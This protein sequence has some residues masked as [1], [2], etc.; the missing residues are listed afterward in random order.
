MLDILTLVQ[1]FLARALHDC[2]EVLLLVKFLLGVLSTFSIEFL[3]VSANKRET[4]Y[5]SLL[6]CIM[7]FNG[8]HVAFS[9]IW[10][11]KGSTLTL[12][13]LFNY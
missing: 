6:I 7:S 9:P 4:I 13:H 3:L 8:T 12:I 11:E 2:S 5:E 10:V 1:L